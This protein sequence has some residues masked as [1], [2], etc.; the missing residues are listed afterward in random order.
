[1]TKPNLL[2]VV[3]SVLAAAIG[4][5]SEKNREIDFKHGSLPAYIIVGLIGTVLFILAIVAIVKLVTS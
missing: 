3:K 2:H 4:V 5:Q 1:M